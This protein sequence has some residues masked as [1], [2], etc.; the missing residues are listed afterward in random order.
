MRRFISLVLCVGAGLSAGLAFA[1]PDDGEETP[2]PSSLDPE[3]RKAVA[4]RFFERAQGQLEADDWERAC[5]NFRVSM[6]YDTSV[7]TLANIARCEEHEGRLYEAWAANNRARFLNRNTPDAARREALND[8]LTR[9]IAKLEAQLPS[10]RV[11]V[12][13]TPPGLAIK[14]DGALMPVSGAG[15]PFPVNPGSHRIS[16]SAPGY[17]TATREIELEPGARTELVIPLEPGEDEPAATPAPPPAPFVA[18]NPRV[19]PDRQTT[20]DEGAIPVWVWPVGAVGLA[21]LGGAIGFGIDSASARSDLGDRC[22]EGADGAFE[23]PDD[24]FDQSGIDTLQRR[25]N[26]GLGLSLG[27]GAVASGTLAAAIIG[28]AQ[29]STTGAAD[30]ASSSSWTLHLDVAPRGGSAGATWRF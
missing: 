1:A 28:L 19:P 27:L 10:V 8:Y 22:A 6:R 13:N 14:S 30:A 4:D 16:V 2:D 23:C 5:R 21:A 29:S 18:P 15:E 25:T 3:A 17:R 24:Q 26:V 11:V 12:P 20:E 7:S 9:A